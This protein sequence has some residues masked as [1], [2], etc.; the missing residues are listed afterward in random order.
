[1]FVA[2]GRPSYFFKPQRGDISPRWGLKKTGEE[3]RFLQTCRSYRAFKELFDL[4]MNAPQ[5]RAKV[6]NVRTVVAKSP[7]L[8]SGK[9]LS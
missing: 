4:L 1:M 2:I 6:A 9:K 8:T 7:G 3:W 5:N